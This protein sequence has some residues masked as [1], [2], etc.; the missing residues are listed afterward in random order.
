M[1]TQLPKQSRRVVDHALSFTAFR[2]RMDAIHLYRRIWRL[3]KNT[4]T[5][6][7][8]SEIRQFAR[9]EFDGL[10]HIRDESHIRQLIVS[11]KTQADG[12]QKMIGLT[13]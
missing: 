13:R 4:P 12:L 1:P 8:R 7:Q 2:L 9:Q 11:G 6:Q 5:E 10:R 3:S